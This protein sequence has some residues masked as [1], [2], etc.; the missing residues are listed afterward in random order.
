MLTTE[1]LNI[2]A[3]PQSAW[4]CSMISI[5]LMKHAMTANRL[6]SKSVGTPDDTITHE[7][8]LEVFYVFVYF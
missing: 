5:L 8:N 2:N 7:K 3:F 6:Y 1:R 4:C